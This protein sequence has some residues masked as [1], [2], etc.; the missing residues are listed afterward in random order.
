MKFEVHDPDVHSEDEWSDPVE[1]RD[2]GV[3]AIQ[4]LRDNDITEDGMDD[5]RR[6]RDEVGA[7]V[8][9]K[10]AILLLV[11]A[12]QD[13][14]A[15]ALVGLFA[16]A[17]LAARGTSTFGWWPDKEM[18]RAN[19]TPGRWFRVA[20]SFGVPALLAVRARN[21]PRPLLAG[22]AGVVGLLAYGTLAARVDGRFAW[23]VCAFT[24]P[25]AL[26]PRRK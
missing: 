19:L 10:T 4:Y 11:A 21:V 20:L 13:R 17:T 8:S 24:V 5:A 12:A 3:A 16:V 26:I 25:M 7:G 18:L 15:L 2:Y 1:A 6:V 23:L 9:E 22:L 14:R